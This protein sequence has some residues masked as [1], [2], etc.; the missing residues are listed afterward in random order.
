MLVGMRDG[1][2]VAKGVW[3][4]QPVSM[5]MYVFDWHHGLLGAAR[6]SFGKDLLTAHPSMD[7]TD[8]GPIAELGGFVWTGGV[9][10]AAK[11]GSRT[12]ILLGFL[13]QRH[14]V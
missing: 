5:R 9:M 3:M 1:E 4:L 10:P 2:V 11:D 7:S 13:K 12:D 8:L 14:F 6:S